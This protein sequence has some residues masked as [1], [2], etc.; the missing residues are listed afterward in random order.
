MTLAAGKHDRAVQALMDAL[1]ALGAGDVFG[2]RLQ[3]AK[4]RL[5][6]EPDPAAPPMP[7]PTT[8]EEPPK[9]WQEGKDE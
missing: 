2:A 3:I 7:L 4:A 6:L 1:T 5:A 9:H 8:N